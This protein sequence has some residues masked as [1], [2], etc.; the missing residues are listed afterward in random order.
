VTYDEVAAERLRD[1]L[2]IILFS[3]EKKMVGSG[4]RCPITKAMGRRVNVCLAGAVPSFGKRLGENSGKFNCMGNG[5][6]HP[7][8]DQENRK[9]LRSIINFSGSKDALENLFGLVD[10]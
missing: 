4:R 3:S 8:S 6:E 9:T 10:I 7:V 5:G 2:E 1:V